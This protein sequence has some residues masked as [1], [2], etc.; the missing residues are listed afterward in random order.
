MFVRLIACIAQKHVVGSHKLSRQFTDARAAG[1]WPEDAD[2]GPLAVA[3]REFT[4]TA[5]ELKKPAPLTGAEEVELKT[6]VDVL[7]PLANMTTKL[8]SV[9]GL[10][11]HLAQFPRCVVVGSSAEAGVTWSRVIPLFLK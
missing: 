9:C 5:A 6:L 3:M 10:K 7:E 1:F 11:Y 2:L 4:K 8:R